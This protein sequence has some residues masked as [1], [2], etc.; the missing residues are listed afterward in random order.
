MN[1]TLTQ[2]AFL[3]PEKDEVQTFHLT[4]AMGRFVILSTYCVLCSPQETNEV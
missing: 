2:D 1:T 3:F 4:A